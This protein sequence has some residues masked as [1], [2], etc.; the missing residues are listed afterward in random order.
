MTTQRRRRLPVPGASPGELEQA[1]SRLGLSLDKVADATKVSVRS[2][3]S[4]ERGD[5]VPLPG[6][7]GPVIRYYEAQLRLLGGDEPVATIAESEPGIPDEQEA[8]AMKVAEVTV[9]RQAEQERR[10]GE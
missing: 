10:T 8:K 9:T 3:G 5:V 1:R 4:W 7:V 6:K 2:L